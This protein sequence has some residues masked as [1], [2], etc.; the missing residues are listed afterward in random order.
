MTLACH[1]AKGKTKR[2]QAMFERAGFSYVYMIYEYVF[3]FKYCYMKKRIFQLL[4]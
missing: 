1:A 2:N 3:L 4:F